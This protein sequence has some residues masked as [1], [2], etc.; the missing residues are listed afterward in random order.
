[1][2]RAGL[3][4]DPAL[5]LRRD[6]APEILECE[7]RLVEEFLESANTGGSPG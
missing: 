5:L 2:R 7:R 6:L 4:L 1:V 3:R